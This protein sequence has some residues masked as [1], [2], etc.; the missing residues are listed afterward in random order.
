MKQYVVLNKQKVALPMTSVLP[1]EPLPTNPPPPSYLNEL[2]VALTQVQP[3]HKKYVLDV[4]H[5]LLSQM[6]SVA[7]SKAPEEPASFFILWLINHLQ[8][9]DDVATP[10]RDWLKLDSNL[11]RRQSQSPDP[12]E[13][14][15]SSKSSKSSSEASSPTNNVVPTQA[16][17]LSFDGVPVTLPEEE[18]SRHSTPL[19]SLNSLSK[20]NTVEQAPAIQFKPPPPPTSPPSAGLAD[21]AISATNSNSAAKDNP[22]VDQPILKFSGAGN[23]M[24]NGGTNGHDKMDKICEV[25]TQPEVAV[26]VSPKQPSR[27][28]PKKAQT[29]GQRRQTFTEGATRTITAPPLSTGNSL[30]EG[31]RRP[32][33]LCVG[34]APGAQKRRPSF[35]LNEEEINSIQREA[36]P[37]RLK[38]EEEG[39]G[40]DQEPVTL[41]EVIDHIEK[42]PMLKR[43]TEDEKEQLAPSF[44]VERY[45]PDQEI[46]KYGQ[47]GGELIIIHSGTCNAME[48]KVAESLVA[49]DTI[50]EQTLFKPHM[51][52]SL[53][54]HAGK[55][56]PVTALRLKSDAIEKLGLNS[57]IGGGGNKLGILKGFGNDPKG[58]RVLG[59]AQK[60]A[61]KKDAAADRRRSTL[62]RQLTGAMQ[63]NGQQGL[64]DRD[65]DN[66]KTKEDK[67][68]IKTALQDN[69]LLM[70]VVELSDDQIEAVCE[71]AISKTVPQRGF[72]LREGD[73]GEHLFIIHDGLFEITKGGH[74]IGK[75]RNGECVGEA[76]L[77]YK[78]PSKSSVRA[79]RHSVV[80][81]L[82]KEQFAEII[83]M[84]SDSVKKEYAKFLCQIPELQA[85]G[86]EDADEAK[87]MADGLEEVLFIKGEKIQQKGQDVECLY[88]LLEGSVQVADDPTRKSERGACFGAEGIKGR[89]VKTTVTVTSENA[90]LLKLDPRVL[91][92]ILGL[93]AFEQGGDDSPRSPDSTGSDKK[94]TS[95]VKR[96]SQQEEE[97]VL[98]RK[99]KD[100]IPRDRLERI[101]VL[102][103]GSFGLV[104]L[105]EDRESKKWYA[106]KALSKGYIASMDLQ[107]HVQNEL[108]VCKMIESHWVVT[109]H[110]SYRDQ[111]FVYFLLEPALGGELFDAYG[112]NP[113][114]FGSSRRARFYTTGA[115]LG[116]EHL[117]SKRVVYRDLKLE[118]ILLSSKGYPL[119]TDMGLAKVVMGKTYTL[120]GT[121][122]FFAPETLRQ[123]GY[124]RA[125][126]WWALGIVLFILMS[127]QSP[128]DAESSQAIYRKIVKGF[129]KETFPSDFSESLVDVIWNC[130]CRKK[131][132]ERLPM[133]PGG[134]NH[135]KDNAWYCEDRFAWDKVAQQQWKAPWIPPV[136]TAEDFKKNNCEHPPVVDYEDDGSGWDFAFVE[137]AGA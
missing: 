5:P 35:A 130:F 37:A 64:L 136:K 86:L 55:D 133:G 20:A 90:S 128:F 14:S 49:G 120:C 123:V 27:P 122:D 1:P 28:A 56:N 113:E 104:T 69:A 108:Q 81:S 9:P 111:Q 137:S 134:V 66:D 129:K 68:V 23:K 89:K 115:A 59:K 72:L 74:S 39:D 119:L 17:R 79:L 102:G 83:S 105:E 121:A 22:A 12:S 2:D 94:Q 29:M 109:L 117:H 110:S 125:V 10:L 100:K 60:P 87:Q 76:S 26:N 118:N 44:A 91:L 47:K 106:L 61:P 19:T 33:N 70:E 92:E 98:K 52:S 57:K 73:V 101:G 93:E 50:G 46:V 30:Q 63:W 3:T 96:A 36:A 126:D 32:S 65:L 127:G 4:L 97:E 114:W 85:A 16:F 80:W 41:E 116:L 112:S 13:S 34:P 88:F 95:I 71:K 11:R 7:L 43:L 77:L 18:W 84:K 15:K 45:Q 51:T 124:N 58:S 31:G 6:V 40:S 48:L 53:A 131:P 54:I 82:G 135:L 62:R 107:E 75:V 67:E 99:I 78:T 103:S 25:T 132:E 8:T 42:I 38:A 24:F 21:K